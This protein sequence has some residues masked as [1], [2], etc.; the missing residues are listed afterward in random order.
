M[1]KNKYGQFTEDGKEYVITNPKTPRAW[2]NYLFNEKYHAICS[3]TGGGFSYYMDPK[4]YRILKWDHLH[5]DRPGR[6]IYMLDMENK[7]MWSAT[8]QPM[9]EKLD[10][11]E[12]RHGLGYTTVKS[13][14]DGIGTEV[15]YFVP[16]NIACEMWLVKVK[17]NSNR[18]REI[19]AFP[20]AHFLDGDPS[21]EAV[22]PQI[23]P[24]Y[25]RADL[26][27]KEGT[28]FIRRVLVPGREKEIVSFY[29]TTGKIDGYDTVKEKFFEPMGYPFEPKPAKTGKCSNSASAGEDTIGVFE[30]GW[31]LAPGEEKEFA[32]SL[33]IVIDEKFRKQIQDFKSLAFVKK[34]LA[35][36][37]KYWNDKIE[38]FV[39]ETPDKAFD[40]MINIWGKYQLIGITNWRGTSPYHGA[41]GGLGY[42]DT[43]Q[44]IEGLLPLDMNLSLAR[45]Q[46][47]LEY[48]YDYGHTVSG[49]SLTEGPWSNEGVTGKAD[50]P[51]WLPYT[52]IAYLKETGDMKFL[53]KKVKYLNKGEGTVYE[54]VLKAVN[55]LYGETGSHGLP[56]IK[57]ADWNDAYDCLGK[58]G[59]GESVW[60]AE[61]LCRALRMVAELADYIGDAKT[62]K[63]MRKKFEIMK[64]RINKHG[65]DS[66][67]YIAAF[68]DAGYKIGCKKN[69]EGVEPLN[70][71]TWAILGGIIPNEVRKKS[72][73][74]IIDGLDTAYGPVLFK[75]GYTKFN[76]EIGRV[77]SFAPG[78]KENA[79]VFSHACAFKVVADCEIKR[80]EE[81]YDTFSKLLPMSPVKL[82]DPD[83]YKGEPYV[84]SEYVV[85]PDHPSN[86]GEGTFTWNTGTSPWMF[87]GGT[88]WI[89]G[90]RPAFDGILIDPCMPKAWNKASMKRP[91]R[92]K[93]LY[94]NIKRQGKGTVPQISVDGKAIEGKVVT[95]KMMG[96]K[97]DIKIDVVLK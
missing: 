83:K 65:F 80:T 32:I 26:D 61:A 20:F 30:H 1:F 74:K 95:M 78:T 43:A 4:T 70:S 87:M 64:A 17:N 52:I 41:E 40:T 36:T 77:T 48:Q 24:M 31:T 54:H 71:Q 86:F 56:L 16:K 96:T 11:W 93:T 53:N 50:V 18:P 91:F 15:T 82:N 84:Y 55:Y 90:V 60:L 5:T 44:D 13:E 94:V 66:G 89:L 7:K 49:F 25:L 3:A 46:L 14:Q 38:E 6:Y 2:F 22:L 21:M 10:K 67:Y 42:R 85:G 97:K 76:G 12:A 63:D 47:I 68:N 69:P 39:V 59:K 79:A 57:R 33:G 9:R 45:M 92:G 19:K 28:I 58:G 37:K 81:A 8:W 29:T 34:E 23:Y 62:A 72:V 51:V 27:K 73:L 75:K 35:F 88:A